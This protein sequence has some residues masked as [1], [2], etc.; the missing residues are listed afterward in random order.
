MG[1]RVKTLVV[2][3]TR[4]QINH[5]VQLDSVCMSIKCGKLLEN[6]CAASL[7]LSKINEIDLKTKYELFEK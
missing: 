6:T 1:L 5:T 3:E 2:D 4:N 7:F